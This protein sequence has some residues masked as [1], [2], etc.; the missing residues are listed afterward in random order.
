MLNVEVA[1]S[2][3]YKPVSCKIHSEYE[4]AIIRGQ[5][6]QVSWQPQTG[7][8]ITEIL[9]PYDV[10]TSQGSEY[11]MAHDINDIDKKIRL[12]KITEAHTVI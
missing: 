12:D 9:K 4:L 11:L 5:R 8:S 3:N 2:D 7:K 6:L 1:M 10:V